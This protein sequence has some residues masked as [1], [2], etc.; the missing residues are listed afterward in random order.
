MVIKQKANHSH[1]VTQTFYR[2]FV[3]DS[4]YNPGDLK[5]QFFRA[6]QKGSF[7]FESIAIWDKGIKELFISHRK[8][9]SLIDAYKCFIHRSCFVIGVLFIWYFMFE[10]TLGHNKSIRP[11]WGVYIGS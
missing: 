2:H 4:S 7:V 9:S 11:S 8:D 1:L 6:V 5:S 10:C 3:Y